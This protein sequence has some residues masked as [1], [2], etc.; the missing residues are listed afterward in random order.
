[1]AGR[2]VLLHDA[3]NKDHEALVQAFFELDTVFPSALAKHTDFVASVVTAY[4][5]LTTLGLNAALT[6]LRRD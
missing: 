5:R 6:A 1:M 4:R 3:H 2:F